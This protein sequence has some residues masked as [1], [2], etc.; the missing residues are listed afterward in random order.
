MILNNEKKLGPTPKSTGVEQEFQQIAKTEESSL[1]QELACTRNGISDE[2]REE[3]LEKYGYNDLSAM[4]KHSWAYFLVHSFADAFIIVLLVLA[5]VTFVVESDILSGTIIL[6]L[7]CMSAVIRFFQDYGSYRDM[8]KLKEMEHDTVRIQVP[9]EDGTEVREV[10]VEEV[11]PGDIPG[12]LSVVIYIFLKVRTYS[13]L[14][15][16]LQGNPFLW[17]NIKVLMIELLMRQN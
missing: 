4:Q 3:R 1:L 2:E 10:P 12:I 11:V 6:A 15:L 9:T 16:P 7:A 14:F 17:R 5:I 8:Q 13:F